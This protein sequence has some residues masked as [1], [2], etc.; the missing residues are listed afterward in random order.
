MKTPL[1]A[2]E[3]PLDARVHGDVDV[4][5]ACYERDAMMVMPIVEGAGVGLHCAK[6]T[7]RGQSAAA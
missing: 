3:T 6:W 5:F 1:E 4:A 2:I 7:V